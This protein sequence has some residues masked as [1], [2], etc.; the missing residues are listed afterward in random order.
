MPLLHAVFE[1]QE[2]A[3]WVYVWQN[4]KDTYVL[5]SVLRVPRVK[6]GLDSNDQERQA[7]AQ[8]NAT[9]IRHALKSRGFKIASGVAIVPK[10]WVTLRIVT[11]PSADTG[12]LGEM[13]RFEAERHIPFHVERHVVSYHVL[14]VEGIRGSQV[15]IAALDG[16]PAEEITAAMDL[17]GIR[18]K[19]IEVSTVTLAN[20]LM[21][22]GKWD[23]ETNPT[24]CQ[25][26]VGYDA[27]DITILHGGIPIFARSIALGVDKV[28]TALMP[29]VS[30]DDLTPRDI[31]RLDLLNLPAF[32][33][34]TEAS[35]STAPQ[36][37]MTP[38]QGTRASARSRIWHERLA[39]EISQT[40]EFARR[41]F[42]CQS[43]S[44]V[45][46]SGP[47]AALGNLEQILRTTLGIEPVRIDP[48]SPGVQ[49][50]GESAAG[51]EP[52]LKLEPGDSGL[53][54]A[55]WAFA[56]AAGAVLRDAWSDAARINL[57]PKSYIDRLA[58]A[59]RNRSMLTTVGLAVGLVVCILA[60]MFQIKSHREAML[61]FYQEETQRNAKRVDEIKYRMTV[62]RI[63]KQNA[64]R[65][66]SALSILNTLSGWGDLFDENERKVSLD[67]F[68]YNMIKGTLVLGGYVRGYPELSQFSQRLLDTKYFVGPPDRDP[69]RI[70]LAP[71]SR[72]MQVIAF[73]MRCRFPVQ[74][75]TDD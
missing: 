37:D 62:V 28:A 32:E 44:K 5:K 6:A 1:Y 24:V 64:S 34:D 26:D 74:K 17:V 70:V 51:A 49:G 33:T 8:T 59:V 7:T 29:N 47:G 66:D 38:P 50:V 3:C 53:A 11:L 22:S 65:K 46:L 61:K 41:Q 12:E 14:R 25:V 43:I 68:E 55:P 56:S 48:F 52:I 9:A 20:A 58:R 69:D 36:T 35:L 10:Q 19:A 13:A 54:D 75:E 31:E 15:L 30:V 4:Q 72:N 27:T 16:P 73:R 39:G 21:R 45:F 71:Y 23:P 57:L 42:E 40:F 60:Y 2:R 18:L 63:L 67:R